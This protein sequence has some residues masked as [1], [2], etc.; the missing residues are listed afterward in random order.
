ML[1]KRQRGENKMMKFLKIYLL[2]ITI[3]FVFLTIVEIIGKIN[4]YRRTKRWNS[5]KFDWKSIILFFTIQF[6]DSLLYGYMTLLQ[7]IF[8]GK[9]MNKYTL[10][11]TDK[12]QHM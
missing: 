8:G 5:H 12:L 9:K 6:L 3:V 10:Y 11:T 4:A 2:G 7:I 1:K